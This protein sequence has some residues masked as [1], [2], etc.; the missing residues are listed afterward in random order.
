[1]FA[2]GAML[3]DWIR[4]D[5]GRRSLLWCM[6]LLFLAAFS[7]RT[8]FD[9]TSNM[10]IAQAEAFVHG[11]TAL[12]GPQHDVS[13]YQG[14]YYC[15]FPPLPALV[16]APLVAIFGTSINSAAVVTLLCGLVTYVLLRR[17]FIVRLGLDATN[18]LWLTAAFMLGTGYW[19][20]ASRPGG[21][22][23]FAHVI[24]IVPCIWI[25]DEVLGKAR[26]W[27]LGLLLGAAFLCRQL[28]I[29]YMILLLF[30]VWRPG[31]PFKAATLDTAMLLVP[32]LAAVSAQLAFNALRFS[33][34][35]DT[36]YR[37]MEG[38]DASSHGMFSLKYLPRNLLLTYFNG[39]HFS[40]SRQQLTV[41]QMD[42]M[43]TSLTFASPFVFLAVRGLKTGSRAVRWG[44]PLT[45]GLIAIAHLLY[46]NN[47]FS[48]TNCSRFTLDFLPLV[49]VLIAL[50]W[51]R[52]DPRTIRTLIGVAIGLNVF[53]LVLAP[54]LFH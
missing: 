26:P 46:Q 12:D 53:S 34:P 39:P 33:G 51:K 21:V 32:V 49:L 23:Y 9:G 35:L 38:V 8:F 15:A 5:S 14:K 31:R 30:A 52:W 24:A 19:M 43:G 7:P 2:F 27:L 25:A 17:L 20:V 4:R 47:G 11:R 37:Y 10:Y 40:F 45:V 16:L 54:R 28:T 41:G 48:Q 18:A 36:G 1:M 3:S 44:I 6:G 42:P 29:I 50:S 13:L 22:W